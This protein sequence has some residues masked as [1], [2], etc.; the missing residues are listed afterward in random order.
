MAETEKA[1]STSAADELRAAPRVK[2]IIDEQDGH[3]GN[4]D[5]QLGIN[6]YVLNIQRGKVVEIPEPFVKLLEDSKYTI[7]GK[8]E[9]KEDIS[10]EQPRFHWRKVA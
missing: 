5:V 2:I 7:I 1:K 9:N 6:G 10:R 3:E 8:D 4:K